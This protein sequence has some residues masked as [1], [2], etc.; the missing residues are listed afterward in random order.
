MKKSD[1]DINELVDAYKEC[2]NLHKLSKRFHTSHIRLSKM[3]KESG[4]EINKLGK[5]RIIS[6]E[7]L[8]DM[9]CDYD[10]NGLTMAE[11]SLK[12]RVRIKKLRQ[13]FK[14]NDVQ[15][16]KWHNHVKKVTEKKPR[17]IKKNISDKTKKCPYCGW[18][19]IDIL[20]KSNAFEKH[21]RKCHQ[22]VNIDE[23]LKKY[24]E[25]KLYFLTYFKRKDK[26]KCEICGKYLNLIDDRH[27]LKYHGITKDKYIEL[28]PDAKLI[29][30]STKE[31]LQYCIQ[32]MNDNENWERNVSVYEKEIIE[33]IKS[34]GL[35]CYRDRKIL[36]GKEIDIFIPEKMVGIEFNGNK[37]HTEWFGGKTRMYHLS[38]TLECNEKGVRLIH[39]FEDEYHFNKEIVLH[40]LRHILGIADI[41]KK[42]MGRKC[43]VEEIGVDI[44]ELFLNANH[45]Q[46]YVNS[47]IHLGC[48]CGGT[49]VGVMSFKK[50]NK[51]TDLWELTRFATIYDYVCQGIGGKLF[52]YFVKK[53]AP[54][55]IK[56]FADRRWTL[57][58]DYN[59]YTKLGFEL[60]GIIKPDYK[61]YNTKIDK[62]KRFHKFNFR[63]QILSKKY[64]FPLT[65]T[66]TEMVKKL[67]Y[68]R[69]WDCGLFK[70]IWKKEEN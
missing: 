70:Y 57:L 16:S 25:D 55:E 56:S 23:H 49:L 19:T 58:S 9:I 12:Y 45:I 24:P 18:E 6:C 20:N 8:D 37:W 63:K 31:K 28:Y 53:Y 7:E 10:K 26:V 5:E 43:Q 17:L 41:S 42:I 52:K 13:L 21:I 30:D 47:T 36:K 3:L 69:I 61:Y 38:K 4:F 15:I 62:F 32:R 1:I 66:E 34:L 44:A 48:F 64:G 14:E 46:G 54:Q 50:E 29:S 60:N 11:I 35:E 68:D 33:Y 2:S 59:L 22:D 39:I 27:L 51:S 40:K 67:G 65:M